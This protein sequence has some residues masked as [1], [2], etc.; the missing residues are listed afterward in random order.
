MTVARVTLPGKCLIGFSP[1]Q[2]FFFQLLILLA[3]FRGFRDDFV[4]YF[5]HFQTFYN[6]SLYDD[7]IV[8]FVVNSYHPYILLLVLVSLRM[9]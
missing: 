3:S 1:L 4:E 6:P 5:V 9:C 8:L 2:K 7:I